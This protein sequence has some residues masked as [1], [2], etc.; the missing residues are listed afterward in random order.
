MKVAN[1]INSLSCKLLGFYNG[2]MQ[3]L[4]EDYKDNQGLIEEKK[5]FL[6]KNFT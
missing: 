6:R 1:E 4:K 3:K 5:E 2:D